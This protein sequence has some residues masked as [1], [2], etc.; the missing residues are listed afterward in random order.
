MLVGPQVTRAARGLDRTDL[1]P[2]ATYNNIWKYGC[3]G[4][5]P[6]I[7]NLQP[8]FSRFLA[9]LRRFA[10]FLI[11]HFIFYNLFV[12]PHKPSDINGLRC[13]QRLD[14]KILW[15]GKS[16]AP[17]AS[18]MTQIYR[19]FWSKK[20]KNFLNFFEKSLLF[21]QTDGKIISIVRFSVHRRCYD[22]DTERKTVGARKATHP[23]ARWRPPR[24]WLS[25][26]SLI[27]TKPI[28][29]DDSRRKRV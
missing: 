27:S 4:A 16:S 12:N 29:I 22:I 13:L 17:R 9:F 20:R 1:F 15:W 26:F 2:N 6:R 8:S 25:P 3:Q 19:L 10:L 28:Y 11:F 14:H 24:E 5:N 21:T 7:F 23:L 18:P